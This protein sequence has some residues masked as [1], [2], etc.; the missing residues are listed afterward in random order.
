VVS[1]RDVD[2]YGLSVADVTLPDG[3]LLN[4]EMVRRGMAW[5]YRKYAPNNRKLAN[6][7]AEAK[8]ARLGL[9]SRS[10]PVAPWDWRHIGAAPHTDIVVGNRRSR[11]YHA[12]DCHAA[13]T[14]DPKNRV[15]FNS[16]S[17]AEKGGYRSA[18]DCW[19][20]VESNARALTCAPGYL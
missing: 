2:R 3:R 7:E 20:R 5:W 1:S 4:R 15:E 9:W 8:T 18:K 17:D 19:S 12:A 16:G 10:H 13:A 6:V 14:V 11:I